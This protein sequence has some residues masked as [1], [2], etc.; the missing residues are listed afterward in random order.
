MEFTK[1]HPEIIKFEEEYLN[2]DYSD[3]DRTCS[4]Y[5]IPTDFIITNVHSRELW[6][7]CPPLVNFD[8]LTC[9]QEIIKKGEYPYN[10][11]V[12]ASFCAKFNIIDPLCEGTTFLSA[13]VYCTQ[14]YHHKIQDEAAAKLVHEQLTAEG[15]CKAT[16]QVLNTLAN[17]KNK[18]FVVLNGTSI[19]YNE[20]KTKIVKALYLINNGTG[21]IWMAPRATR[22]GY[23]AKVGQYI[24]PA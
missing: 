7:N 9:I 6:K 11:T 20:T 14:A 8:M 19:L 15:F 16:T 21:F 2:L 17:T 3:P 13:M 10:S 12:Q 4:F 5:I 1:Y 24:K 22:K 23:I 18:A